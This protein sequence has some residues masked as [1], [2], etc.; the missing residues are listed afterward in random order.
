MLR[1]QISGAYRTVVVL[2]VVA[3][4]VAA[5][6]GVGVVEAV[7]AVVAVAVAAE[8]SVVFF[9]SFVIEKLHSVV[10]AAALKGLVAV[11]LAVV[12]EVPPSA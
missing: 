8:P 4:V 7:V 11:H 5:G 10:A 1:F 2:V 9:L 6:V 12:V 3:A